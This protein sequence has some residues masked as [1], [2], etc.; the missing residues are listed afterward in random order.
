MWHHLGGFNLCVIFCDE[1]GEG[2][3]KFSKYPDVVLERTL[4]FQKKFPSDILAGLQKS[5]NNKIKG[6]NV[7]NIRFREGTE[8][9]RNNFNYF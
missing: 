2:S 7:K 9:L 4:T 1:K 8:T 5:K 3:K 6:L